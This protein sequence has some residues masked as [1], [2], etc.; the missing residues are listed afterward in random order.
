MDTFSS[1]VEGGRSRV[2]GADAGVGE[3]GGGESEE[4]AS[5]FTTIA[6]GSSTEI[7][8]IS[9][10]SESS[11][12]LLEA[13]VEDEL[14]GRPFEFWRTTSSS[15]LSSDSAS[16]PLRAEE[17]SSRPERPPRSRPSSS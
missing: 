8:S 11:S 5:E 17:S 1:S 10:S 6:G 3:E 15:G 14:T 4:V 9:P 12:L 13:S 16:A 7:S 2:E